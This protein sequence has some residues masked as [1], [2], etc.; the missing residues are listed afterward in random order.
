MKIMPCPLNGNRNIS[1]FV[2]GG[3]VKRLP[4]PHQASDREWADHLFLE[5]NRMGVVIEWWMHVAS[6]YWFIAERD[7]VTDEI[8]RTYPARE[9]FN[10]RMDFPE[11]S[12]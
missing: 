7:T 8:V 2:C 4:H 3:E 11:S 1:E 9:L 10:S 12:E 6:G 5:D